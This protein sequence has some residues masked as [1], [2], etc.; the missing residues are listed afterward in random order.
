MNKIGIIALH[1]LLFIFTAACI[2]A[3]GEKTGSGWHSRNDAEPVRQDDYEQ[4]V[5]AARKALDMAEATVGPAH[6]YVAISLNNLAS[7][8]SSRGEYAR[9]ALLYERSLAIWEKAL[10]PDHPYVA[11][12]LDELSEVYRA[13]GKAKAAAEVEQRIERIRGS[14]R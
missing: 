6:P 5:E 3:Q 2:H 7:L 11:S 10:G 1:L 14:K 13:M 9:A 8:Y 4:A 12:C